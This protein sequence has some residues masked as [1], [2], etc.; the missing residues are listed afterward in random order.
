VNFICAD[1][2]FGAKAVAVSILNLVLAFR[3]TLAESTSCI[4]S[5]SRSALRNVGICMMRSMCLYG[6]WLH[7]VMTL[8]L[9]KYSAS[10]LSPS[11]FRLGLNV[12]YLAGFFAARSSVPFASSAALAAAEKF[13]AKIYVQAVFQELQTADIVF[14]RQR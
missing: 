8:Y 14:S 2:Y 4:N 10:I 9:N 12:D 13:C 11:L 5:G 6:R 3:I 1:A 7:R